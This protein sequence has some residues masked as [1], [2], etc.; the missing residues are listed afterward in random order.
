M[1]PVLSGAV[2]QLARSAARAALDPWVRELAR[3]IV[4][5]SKGLDAAARLL[6]AV[7]DRVAFEREPKELFRSPRVTW[8]RGAG[9]CDDSAVLLASLAS[10]AGL[11][12]EL[13]PMGAGGAPTHVAAR[14][15]G[16]WAETTLRGA[17]LGEH[18]EAALVRL[19]P[20]PLRMTGP[21]S[22][23]GL[24]SRGTRARAGLGDVSPAVSARTKY[25]A[26]IVS[27]AWN[28]QVGREPS[29]FELLYAMCWS[30]LESSW[31]AGW[32]GACVGSHNWGA[33]QAKDGQP[34]CDWHDTYP[35]GQTYEQRFR[36]YPSDLDGAADFV[37]HLV[38][39]R[40][41]TAAALAR[42]DSMRAVAGAMRDEKYFGGFCPNATNQGQATSSSACREEALDLAALRLRAESNIICS[43]MGWPKPRVLDGEP[44]VAWYDQ[45]RG[46]SSSLGGVVLLAAVGAGGY[47]LW[48]SQKKPKKG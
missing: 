20:P 31:G 29:R 28:Q 30:R 25:A 23:P 44:R 16:R 41:K 38:I 3:S 12:A 8:Q 15:F 48:R 27:E 24:F 21:S 32:G 40:P 26:G 18:P 17:R 34:G 19:G 7:Q 1:L 14:L 42:V 36:V 39:L 47:L 45:G 22:S 2:P 4:G 9:D 43:V 33:V 13:V 11:P 5:D 46:G 10:A 6:S 37:R 35:N